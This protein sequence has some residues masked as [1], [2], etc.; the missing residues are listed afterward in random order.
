MDSF[1]LIFRVASPQIVG[2]SFHDGEDENSTEY[3]VSNTTD[4]IVIEI[5]VD[6]DIA[7]AQNKGNSIRCVHVFFPICI[8]LTPLSYIIPSYSIHSANL[9]ILG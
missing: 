6:M 9:W 1:L 2:L 4:S 7:R 3:S 8:L 5:T